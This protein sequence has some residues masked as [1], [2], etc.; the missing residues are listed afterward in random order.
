MQN[1]SAVQEEIR[2]K[3]DAGEIEVQDDESYINLITTYLIMEKVFIDLFPKKSPKI[4]Y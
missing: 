1:I 2:G 3:S 4:V